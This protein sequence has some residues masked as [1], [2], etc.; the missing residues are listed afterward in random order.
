MRTPILML[1]LLILI[2]V[3]FSEA[4]KPKF[5]ICTSASSKETAA[6]LAYFE[7]KAFNA[8][9]KEF[10]CVEISSQSTIASVLELERMKQLLGS[11]ERDLSSIGEAMGSDYLV[12]LKVTGTTGSI[13]INAFCADTRK[14][15]VIA[16]AMEVASN[17][18]AAVEIGRAHV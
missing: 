15:K 1:L 13:M 2:G 8:L 5:F 14:S 17:A 6:Y 16:R 18:D 9:K 11:E 10:P 7:S 4:A 3:K 12:S